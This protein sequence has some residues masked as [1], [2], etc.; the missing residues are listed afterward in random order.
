MTQEV[1]RVI[2]TMVI[3]H[4]LKSNEL[5]SILKRQNFYEHKMKVILTQN[6]ENQVTP[7]APHSDRHRCPAALKTP[8]YHPPLLI[9]STRPLPCV[10]VCVCVCMRVC[11]CVCVCVCVRVCVCVCVCVC[12]C[13]CVCVCVCLC[14][15]RCMCV[16][17]CVC[18]LICVQ[19]YMH[20]CVCVCVCVCVRVCVCA[21]VCVCVCV[22]VCVNP[23]NLPI[24]RT[25][26][27]W[28]FHS[29][30]YLLPSSARGG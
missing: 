15:C 30:P 9:S 19:I 1:S 12:T 11:V 21:C 23:N 20:V 8:T 4:A 17:V 10:C 2:H 29:Y 22:S 3:L 25:C 27:M 7:Q 24:P 13:V 16:C 5:P 28:P 18:V 26:L 6:N 14:M